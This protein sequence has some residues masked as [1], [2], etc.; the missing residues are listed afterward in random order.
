MKL[1]NKV[2]VVTASITGIGYAALKKLAEHGATTYLAAHLKDDSQKVIDDL[3]KQGLDVKYV[4]FDAFDFTTH[5]ACIEEVVK[6]EGRI[7][8]LV[9]NFGTGNPAKDLD[10]VNGDT[11]TFFQTVDTNI[12]SVYLTSKAAI[13]HMIKQGGGNIVNVSSIG[14]IMP[15][16]SRLGY[17]VSKAAINSLTQN[18]AFEYARMGIRCNAIMPGMTATPAV[19]QCMTEEFSQAYLKHVP[20]GRIAQPEEMANA[21]L[22]FASDDSSYVTGTIQNMAGGFGMGTP[23]FGDYMSG[24]SLG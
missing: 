3:T 15:D 24:N 9:N 1:Q 17:M 4:Y 6:N 14:S 10:L 23:M 12:K 18:I 5:A 11:E 7:D 16:L 22:Y 8:I 20:L 2:A 13:P 19:M 21:I